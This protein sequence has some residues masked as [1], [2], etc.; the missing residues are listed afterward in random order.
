M[1]GRVAQVS[2]SGYFKS[3]HVMQNNHL[4]TQRR[5][6]RHMSY[7]RG[8]LH[9]VPLLLAKNRKRKAT[10]YQD[11]NI[12]SNIRLVNSSLVTFRS[13]QNIWCKYEG[14]I[15]PILSL[16]FPV[17]VVVR[18]CGLFFALHTLV[19]AENYLNTPSLHEYCCY[20]HHVPIFWCLVPTG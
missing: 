8:R 5:F 20:V 18:L 9:Q 14:M 7:S 1:V 17:A 6:L 2:Q 12:W 15:H 19:P 3:N 4:W 11:S 13:G 10:V 16:R